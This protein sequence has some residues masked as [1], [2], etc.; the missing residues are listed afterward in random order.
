MP[1]KPIEGPVFER[2]TADLPD[3]SQGV[4]EEAQDSSRP[5]VVSISPTNDATGIGTITELHVRFDQPMDPLSLKLDWESGG[6]LDCEF[7]KYDPKKYEFTI[8]V[9]LSPGV[10]QQIVV[11][12]PRFGE[13]KFR[14]EAQPTP[15][16]WFPVVGS[17]SD[18]FV[19]LAFSHAKPRRPRRS[20]P[21]PQVTTISPAPGSQVPFRTFLEIQFDQ[22]MTPPA[23]AFPYLLSKPGMKEPRM[24]SRVQ[25]DAARHTFRIPVCCCRPMKKWSSH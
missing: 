23:E 25:Y 2:S 8:P 13:D 6:F 9:Q 24:I 10:L 21:P 11:N 5:K 18:G 17:P 20:N 15:P 22:P 16:G 14:P 1:D 19:C 12:K 7:P 4:K 3:H